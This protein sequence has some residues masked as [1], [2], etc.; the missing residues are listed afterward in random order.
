MTTP[1][2]NQKEKQHLLDVKYLL[3]KES[4]FCLW[5]TGLFLAMLFLLFPAARGGRHPYRKILFCAGVV[6]LG[7]II[8]GGLFLSA[9]FSLT[10]TAFHLLLF[11]NDLWLLNPA[12]D[13]LVVL[14]PEAF[15][16]AI[17]RRLVMVMIVVYGL[18]LVGGWI[19]ERHTKLLS[20]ITVQSH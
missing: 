4:I 8:L 10:F 19:A 2:F 13:N 9:N 17:A 11:T 14:F 7:G 12:T 18:L 15:W 20:R 3:Q 16:I 1:F 6:G 5:M